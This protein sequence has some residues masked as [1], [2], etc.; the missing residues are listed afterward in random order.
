MSVAARLAGFAAILALVFGG[1]AFAGGRIDAD[2][3]AP[4]PDAA[5]AG[6]MGA[7]GGA[8]DAHGAGAGGGKAAPQAVL[9][10]AVSADGLTLELA[11][12]TARP[13]ERFDLAFRIADRR[14]RTVRAFDVEHKKR[15]H[16][17][18]VRRDMTGFQ[19]LHPVQRA[20]GSWSVPA[21]L[22][23]P[24]SYRV[25]ADFSAGGKARTLAGDL[26]ADGAVRSRALPAPAS[27]ADA[28]GG[29]Q[30]RLAPGTTRAGAEADL[31]FTVTR[32]GRRVAVE[33]YLGAKGHLVALREGDLG[34]LHVHPDEH[35]LRFMAEL[36][37]AGRYRL[38][39]QF[40]AGGRVHTAA[41][42]REVSR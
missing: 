7:M 12:T 35:R 14:G 19:H 5:S 20:D 2:P 26:T 4:E 10:L 38:F 15:M 29:L 32:G 17:I 21:T 6:G 36:P 25:F 13:G 42:T 22:S 41:F 40:K 3:A 8:E 23:D 39:L 24:G 16:V 33:D 28:G 27:V 1:A 11:R 37:T 30:V 18:V 31:R 34:F 9:G